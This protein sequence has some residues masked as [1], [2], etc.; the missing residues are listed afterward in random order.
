ME[1]QPRHRQFSCKKLLLPESW[2]LSTE[3]DEYGQVADQDSQH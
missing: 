3:Y 1:V 2:A